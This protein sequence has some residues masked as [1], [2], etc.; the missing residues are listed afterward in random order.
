MQRQHLGGEKSPWKDRSVGQ[1][2][3]VARRNNLVGGEKPRSRHLEVLDREE[4]REGRQAAQFTSVR[5]AAAQIFDHSTR[6]DGLGRR[7][8]YPTASGTPGVRSGSF[9]RTAAMACHPLAVT[10]ME[11][12]GQFAA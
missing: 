12:K 4:T 5:G 6:K 11:S 8:E 3:T 9:R 2:E 7:C 10:C 1:P